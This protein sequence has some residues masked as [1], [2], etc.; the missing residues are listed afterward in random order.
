V[1]QT[2]KA[3]PSAIVSRGAVVRL[4][5]R[6]RQRVGQLVDEDV[7]HPLRGSGLNADRPLLVVTESFGLVVFAVHPQERLEMPLPDH[8][9]LDE[10]V[11]LYL[12]EACSLARAAELARVTRWDILDALNA[13][14]AM[15]RPGDVRS[16][17]EMDDLVERLEQ[18]GIL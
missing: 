10:A 1:V 2:P 18:Q 4:P 16:A 9:T 5:D 17:D 7:Q 3:T 15:Q 13:R 12:A 6:C 8:A 14:G 11:E